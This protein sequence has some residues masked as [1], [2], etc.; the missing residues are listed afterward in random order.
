MILA[1]VMV[2]ILLVRYL[3]VVLCGLR[4][5]RL[6]T[7]TAGGW[8]CVLLVVTACLLPGP[9]NHPRFRVPVEPILSV[10]AAIGYLGLMEWRRRKASC[11]DTGDAGEKEAKAD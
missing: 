9:A 4:R 3:G 8:L 1:G 10:A 2:M 6:R 11:R 7:M 5:L